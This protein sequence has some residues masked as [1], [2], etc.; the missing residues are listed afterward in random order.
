MY[1]WRGRIVRDLQGLS[2]LVA[3][4]C[5]LKV[6]DIF[7]TVE[8]IRLEAFALVVDKKDVVCPCRR[9]RLGG[10]IERDEACVV[11]AEF[12]GLGREE[13]FVLF[14]LRHVD[15]SQFMVVLSKDQKYWHAAALGSR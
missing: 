14:V 8:G 10:C 3:C 5:S 9:D 4:H 1:R 6:P 15:D 12:L 13:E 7:G 11:H 2:N